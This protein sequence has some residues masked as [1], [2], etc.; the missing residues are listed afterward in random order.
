MREAL[1]TKSGL[2]IP[3]ISNSVVIASQA[4]SQLRGTKQARSNR[5][6]SAIALLRS[7]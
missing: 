2:I 5:L 6:V 3:F 1:Y 4:R 7:Q